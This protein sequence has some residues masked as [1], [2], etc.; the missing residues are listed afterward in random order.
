LDK[1]LD[2]SRDANEPVKIND[3]NIVHDF[4]FNTI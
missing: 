1:H 3:H 4:N 2:A